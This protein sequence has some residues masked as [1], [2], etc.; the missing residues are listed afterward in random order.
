MSTE[1]KW[2]SPTN[3][4]TCP[5]CGE[6]VEECPGVMTYAATYYQ[7][8][9]YECLSDRQVSSADTAILL[10]YTADGTE[11]NVGIDN[12]EELCYDCDRATDPE[13]YM[14]Y[15]PD[16]YWDA[17]DPPDWVISAT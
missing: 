17:N 4:D 14:D 8:A 3:N 15:E 11:C 10:H 9:E 7:P 13:S 5:V 2:I 16:D 6:T 12:G 1:A